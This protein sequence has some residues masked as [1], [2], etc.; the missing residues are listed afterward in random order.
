MKILSSIQLLLR[1]DREPVCCPRE[2][3]SL[4][5]RVKAFFHGF[6]TCAEG[7]SHS[8]KDHLNSSLANLSS[9]STPNGPWLYTVVPWE[10]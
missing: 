8:V 1:T 2:D 4:V 6:P 7:R 9:V 3:R 5:D 10:D